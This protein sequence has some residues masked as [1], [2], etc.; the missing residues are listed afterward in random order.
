MSNKSRN[1]IIAFSAVA[2]IAMIAFA[3]TD[4]IYP[5]GRRVSDNRPSRAATNYADLVRAGVAN[6]LALQ[7]APYSEGAI[8]YGD[9]DGN[10]ESSTVGALGDVAAWDSS[11]VPGATTITDGAGIETTKTDGDIAFALA[12]DYAFQTVDSIT[13]GVGNAGAGTD[14]LMQ[15]EA[16]TLADNQESVSLESF[17]ATSANGNNKQI[18]A[19]ISIDGGADGVLFDSGTVAANNKVYSIKVKIAR[20]D[21]S[22]IRL[23]VIPEAIGSGF[24]AAGTYGDVACT[25][26]QT[27]RIR[28]YGVGTADSDAYQLWLGAFRR[29]TAAP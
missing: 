19:K 21:A 27:I 9:D 17:F 13:T 18:L 11:G 25:A 15:T 28:F 4:A 7:N 3:D 29:P 14:L 23:M 20:R 12:D 2:F 6:A 22:V 5:E 1:T 26:G 16:F 8:L 24:S 10:P